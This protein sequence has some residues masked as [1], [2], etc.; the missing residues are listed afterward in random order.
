MDLDWTKFAVFPGPVFRQ[1]QLVA[2]EDIDGFTLALGIVQAFD[3]SSK[4]VWMFTKYTSMQD[5]NALHL[6][7]VLLDSHTFQDER[8]R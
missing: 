4:C 1:N 5:V 6:G 2:L 8:L 3:R 7:D